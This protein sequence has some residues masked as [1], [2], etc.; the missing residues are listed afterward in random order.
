MPRLDT[1]ALRTLCAIADHGGITRAAEHLALTQSAVSHKIKRLESSIGCALLTRQP[2]APLMSPDGQRL[3]GYARRICALHD[4]ALQSLSK[5]ALSGHIRLGMTEDVTSSDL[6]RILGRFTRRY[7][8]VAVRTHVR[9]SMVLQRALERGELDISMMQIFAPDLRPTDRLLYR[10]RV[11]WVRAK[12]MKLQLDRPLPFLAYDEDCFFRHWAMEEG[13]TPAPGLET[14]LQC[15]SSAGI[16]SAVQSGLG[17]A[18]LPGRYLTD[19]MQIIDHLFLP[20]PELAYVL[21][22][23]PQARAAHVLAFADEVG[24]GE[25]GTGEIGAKESDAKASQRRAPQLA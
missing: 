17:V 20:A 12:D 14:V 11:H 18:L 6:S 8:D 23:A 19:E 25:I 7:P 3:L 15:A 10:D 24:A 1:E 4:E 21:R 2:G 5:R 9:Q 13:N 16:I 22:I